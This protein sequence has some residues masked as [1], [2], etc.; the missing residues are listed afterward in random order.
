MPM[1]SHLVQRIISTDKAKV[2]PPP[3]SNKKLTPRQIDM[4]RQWIAEGA[5][6][7]PHWAFIAPKRPSV[8]GGKTSEVWVKNPIDAFILAR[9]NPQRLAPMPEADPATYIRRVTLDLTG[10]P[11]TIA[12]INEF[13]HDCA[14]A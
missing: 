6:W 5:V 2:M 13:L 7:Q 11:P 3:G 10:L 4:L 9:L 12:E 8:P 1:Q 14:N